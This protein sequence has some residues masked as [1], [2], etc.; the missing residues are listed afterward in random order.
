MK[1][2]IR[3]LL[4]DFNG[5]KPNLWYNILGLLLIFVLIGLLIW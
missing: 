3:W 2:I 1:K 4:T 5:N